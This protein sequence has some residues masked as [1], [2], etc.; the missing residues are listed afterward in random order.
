MGGPEAALFDYARGGPQ[1]GSDGLLIGPPLSP[2]M[3]GL[4]GP[5]SPTRGA[6]D[7]R[8]AKSRLGLS[9]AALPRRSGG[10]RRSL[11]GK[12]AE[13][14]GGGGGGGVGGGSDGGRDEATLKEVTVYFAPELAKL[15]R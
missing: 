7:L 15:Y 8:S 11:F 6:G 13:G 4:A 2:V 5:D 1:F 3:G 9:Y 12:G 10:G 14:G